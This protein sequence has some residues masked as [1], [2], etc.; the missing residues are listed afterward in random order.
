MICLLNFP[1]TS[2]AG[3]DSNQLDTTA[4]VTI[5]TI[6]RLFSMLKL[7]ANIMAM[8]FQRI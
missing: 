8:E 5:C 2:P 6:Q 3:P 7:R 4:R 1:V